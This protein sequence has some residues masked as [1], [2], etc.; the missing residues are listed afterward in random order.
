MST[1]LTTPASRRQAYRRCLDEIAPHAADTDRDH[2][3]ELEHRADEDHQQ[4]L[5][6]A[7]AGPQD[8]QRDEGRGRQIAREGDEGFEKGLDAGL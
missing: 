4:L 7:D 2:Q 8:Q 5:Q 1:R 3:D 6:F